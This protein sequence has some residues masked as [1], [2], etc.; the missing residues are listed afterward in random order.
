[1]TVDEKKYKKNEKAYR[2]ALAVMSV[3]L[4]ISVAFH[5]SEPKKEA[6]KT[7]RRKEQ[8]GQ[9]EYVFFPPFKNDPMVNEQDMKGL[10]AFERER[11]V[12]VTVKA[13]EAYNIIETTKLLQE[14]IEEEPDGIIL[15]ASEPILIPYINQAV[16]K[17]IPVVTVDADMPDSKR[18]AYIGSDWF[19]I[20]VS[21]AEAIVKLTGGKGI[22]AGLGITGNTNM[23]DGWEGF[24][25][26]LSEYEDIVVLGMYDDVSNRDEAKR[27]TLELLDE[28]PG[29]AAFAAF[30]S[31]S[32][33]GICRAL[34]E[35]GKIQDIDVVSVDM[36]QEHIE[37]L[38]KGYVKRL[39]G[40]KRE[41]F[42]YYGGNL[43][44][45]YNHG[46]LSVSN[47]DDYNGITNIPNYI[48][49]GLVILD[50]EDVK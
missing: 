17:G 30:D 24:N 43:I 49:T 6:E 37:L 14:T 29:I 16:E 45:E 5:L 25:H 36:T 47:Q 19:Q 39:V 13:P 12:K 38:K 34:E 22:V 23:V 21:Q 35:R 20:G 44:Y 4:L 50:E 31:N 11:D 1:M 3:L 7:V 27:I 48:D 15:C 32:A 28:Y 42:A 8:N 46:V 41:L 33:F 9:E 2:W 10:E 26:I 18:L 40:Q